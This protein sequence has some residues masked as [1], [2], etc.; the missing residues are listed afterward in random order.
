MAIRE[1]Y[2]LWSEDFTKTQWIKSAALVES[3]TETS[4][5]GD[6]AQVI[7]LGDGYIY[8]DAGPAVAL[9]DLVGHAVWLKFVGGTGSATMGFRFPG[10]GNFP[11][12]VNITV[13]NTWTKY[14]LYGPAVG[15][16]KRFLIDNR[17]LGGYSGLVRYLAI[18]QP[19]QWRGSPDK[20]YVKTEGSIILNQFVPDVSQQRQSQQQY[21]SLAI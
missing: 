1:N 19:Q 9:N 17:A 14:V 3:Y 7:R 13:T 15:Q 4:P 11:D 5:L 2:L 20:Q 18:W 12:N 8:Q 6:E 16:G 21:V 10:G